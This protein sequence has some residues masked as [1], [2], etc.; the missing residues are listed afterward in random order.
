MMDQIIHAEHDRTFVCP[1][2][3]TEN[4]AYPYLESNTHFQHAFSHLP[5]ELRWKIWE[6]SLPGPRLVSIR[7]GSDDLGSRSSVFAGCTSPARI[8]A[9]LHANHESRR[10]ALRH[11]Q[12]AFGI[13]HRPGQIFFS[14][15]SDILHFGPRSG[16]MAS[17]AQL[18]TVLTLCNPNDL[19]HVRKVAIN[20]AVFWIPAA[21]STKVATSL[22]VDVLRLLRTRMPGL[23]DLMIVP[24][25]NQLVHSG[26]ACLL[27]PAMAPSP[28][29]LARIVR[30]AMSVVFADQQSSQRPWNW[31]IMNLNAVSGIP[32][33]DRQVLGWEAAK[34]EGNVEYGN[35]HCS[36]YVEPGWKV[37]E[38]WA[39]QDRELARLSLLQESMRRDFMHMNVGSC[40][41][42]VAVE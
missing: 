9:N 34:R 30:E 40:A 31:A 36:G 16:Y 37:E 2:R 3:A 14:A 11:Y 23:C 21:G 5:A 1:H 27:E 25:S 18:R 41:V 12:A 38:H 26:E 4:C 10:E 29:P 13:A 22:L 32:V 7:C 28:S 8:P 33:H 24:R 42:S 39:G 17:E 15:P 6:Y 35:P 19:A 20:D